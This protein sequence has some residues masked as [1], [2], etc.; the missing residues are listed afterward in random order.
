MRERHVE[1][2]VGTYGSGLLSS[3]A[4]VVR[5]HYSLPVLDI[6]VL[7]ECGTLTDLPYDTLATAVRLLFLHSYDFRKFGRRRHTS[8][9][10]FI[11][12]PI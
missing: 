2:L 5:P 4:S 11:I 3:P 6:R 8:K 9:D 12:N 10:T 1:R 7:I